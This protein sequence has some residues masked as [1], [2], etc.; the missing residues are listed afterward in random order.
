MK[1]QLQNELKAALLQEK[2]KLE[3]ELGRLAHRVVQAD[4][5][6]KPVFEVD[7]PNFGDSE[8][9]N[10]AEIAQYSDN[11]SLE[12]ELE[13]ALKDV[14]TAL[15]AME[16]GTYGICKYCKQPISEERLKVRPTS[17]S[18]IACKK[19]LTQEL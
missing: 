11:L 4:G 15:S 8:D 1:T 5:G 18:C 2:Q 16:N 10:A 14:N 13:W 6:N 17:T 12:H 9:E 7:Y 3:E 19:T